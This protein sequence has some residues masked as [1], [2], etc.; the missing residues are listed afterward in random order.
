MIII[1]VLQMDIICILI[2]YYFN[3]MYFKIILFA[4]QLNIIFMFM[5]I[6]LVLQMDN[7]CILIKYYFHVYDR[8]SCI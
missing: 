5:I 3:I 6:I 8:N 1:Q 4:F 7:N 2:K